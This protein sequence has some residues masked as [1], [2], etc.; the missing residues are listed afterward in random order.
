VSR[1]VGGSIASVRSFEKGEE[2]GVFHLGSTVAFAA[3]RLAPDAIAPR[4]IRFGQTIA[5]AQ[6]EGIAS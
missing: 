2:L 4:T 3:E 5:R 6:K 1:D